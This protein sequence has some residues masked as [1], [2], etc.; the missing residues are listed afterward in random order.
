MKPRIGLSSYPYCEAHGYHT[1]RE[2]VDAVV[3]AGGVPMLLPPVG[4]DM[5]D[6][7][8]DGIDALVLI[9]GGDIDPELYGSDMHDTIYS[10]NPVRD[11]TELA[12]AGA[13]LASDMPILAICRGLQL[14]NVACGGSLHVHL[15]EVVGE[16]TLHRSETRTQIKHAVDVAPDS[17]L[18]QT[19]GAAQVT[20]ASWHHQAVNQLGEGLSAVA[21][22]DDGTIEAIESS[23][24]AYLLAVQWH[25]ELTAAA[26]ATQ[27][28]IFDGLVQAALQ[29]KIIRFENN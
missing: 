23:R 1:P 7:W 27:Q 19:M 17:L 22:A 18:G 21:W 6:A 12:L 20:T 25:P 14:I 26:D 4:V 2:Y 5:I 16:D 29:A 10:L 11:E 28:N 13:A 15:P 8:L 9:G 24:A 3:R